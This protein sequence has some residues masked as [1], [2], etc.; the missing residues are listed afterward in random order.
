MH[1]GGPIIIAFH[2]LRSD[3]GKTL[4]ESSSLEVKSFN[5]FNIL[6]IYPLPDPALPPE[7]L[8]SYLAFSSYLVTTELISST[9]L[10]N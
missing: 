5:S 10:F 4:I 9:F 6:F 3:A 2:S 8:D 1:P 7:L